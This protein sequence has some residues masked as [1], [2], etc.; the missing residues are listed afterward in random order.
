M[1]NVLINGMGVLGRRLFRMIWDNELSSSLATNLT[2]TMINDV[3]ITDLTQLA[4]LLQYDTVYGRWKGHTV[5]V[6]DNNRLEID[7]KTVE[8]YSAADVAN[9]QLSTIAISFDC[10][11]RVTDN[12]L[13]EYKTAGSHVAI[14]VKNASTTIPC[15]ISGINDQGY[16]E[17]NGYAYSPHGDLIAI[18]QI[19]NII[20]EKYGLSNA[21]TDEI[22]AYTNL[23]NLEDSAFP[24]YAS[25]SQVGRAG[26]WNIIP[27]SSSA[28]KILGRIFSALSGKANGSTRNVGVITGAIMDCFVQTVNPVESVDALKM[29][30]KSWLEVDHKDWQME[31]AEVGYVSSDMVGLP[32]TCFDAN[33]GVTMIGN[34]FM[35]VSVIYDPITVAAANAALVGAYIDTNQ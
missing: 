19:L 26:A 10:T 7:A 34:N 35:R 33:T 25:T 22:T 17:A 3:F 12:I 6:V 21:I 30:I 16:T 9:L 14:G 27:S 29:N 28:P 15:I 1:A 8:V 23:N 32:Y 13:D 5:Q 24:A 2:V 18:A 31:Y 11:G 4:Y 20:N